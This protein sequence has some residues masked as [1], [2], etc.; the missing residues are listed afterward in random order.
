MLAKKKLS[1]PSVNVLDLST[2]LLEHYI[3]IN[4]FG[5]DMSHNPETKLAPLIATGTIGTS[6]TLAVSAI[7]S[8]TRVYDMLFGASTIGSSLTVGDGTNDVVPVTTSVPFSV[9]SK[10]ID[11]QH[12]PL[13]PSDWSFTGSEGDVVW[14]VC[15]YEKPGAL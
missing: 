1:L 11:R 3:D 5:G 15:L 7:I 8:E 4:D 12:I 10:S 13:D 2:F 9:A 14:V 6:S